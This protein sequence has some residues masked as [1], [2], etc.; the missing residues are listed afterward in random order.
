MNVVPF[1]DRKCVYRSRNKDMHNSFSVAL[2]KLQFRR[3][4]CHL[5]LKCYYQFW[6]SIYVLYLISSPFLSVF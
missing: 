2:G 1:Q 4:N 5:L 6:V 3:I